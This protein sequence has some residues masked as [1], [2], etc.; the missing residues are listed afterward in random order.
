MKKNWKDRIAAVFVAVCFCLCLLA[1]VFSG[2]LPVAA[3]GVQ[4][5]YEEKLFSTDEPITVNFIIEEDDWNNMLQ[6][7]ISEEYV[8]C[9]VQVNGE[10]FYGVGVRPKGNTSLS[11]IANDPDTDRYSFKIE[12]DHYVDG[13]TCYGLDK[14]ILNNNYADATCMKEA[15]VY[16][17][18]Q[19][20]DADA[21][22]YNYAKI[23][24][25]GE[26]WGVY[27]A[28]EAVEDSFLLRNYGVSSGNLYKPEG[29]GIGGGGG[30]FGGSGGGANLNYTDDDPDSYETIWDGALQK[31]SDKDKQRVIEG[32]SHAA[33]GT[34][35]DEY[36]DIDNLLRYMAVHVFAA[37]EDSLS[38]TMAHNYY[39]YEQ[40][41][42]L[43]VLPWDY[44][45]AWGGMGAQN[46][47]RIINDDIY[48]PFDSTDFFD[49]LLQDENYLAQ[50]EAYLQELA[51]HYAESGG[52]EEFIAKNREK[53]DTLQENDPTAF[54][55]YEE[56]EAAVETL[57]ETITLR[58]KAIESQLAGSTEAID[59]G[60][61]DLSVMG[62]MNMGNGGG[63]GGEMPGRGGKER[64]GRAN[65]STET[66]LEQ[67]GTG[68]M[69]E[70]AT[71]EKSANEAP[72][73]QTP[74]GDQPGEPPT[75][76]GGEMP[77]GGFDDGQKPDGAPEKP[78]GEA[79][80]NAEM[81]EPP[82][83]PAEGDTNEKPSTLPD[84]DSD[85]A[86]QQEEAENSQPLDDSET[87]PDST[88]EVQNPFD[89]FDPS[90]FDGEMPDFEEM[91]EKMGEM[92]QNRPEMGGFDMGGQS[93]GNSLLSWAIYGGC[94]LLLLAGILFA[95]LYRRKSYPKPKCGK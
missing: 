7:A 3:Q 92:G 22:L 69:V 33:D 78:A 38:G 56:Y 62:T 40:D 73:G 72:G 11:S 29:M 95:T 49:A 84:E 89:G 57:Q 5:E 14:L 58:G 24:V 9:D 15:L 59:C 75:G 65:D 48:D 52:I 8:Q 31:V 26:Y 67:S 60:D 6:N 32:L 12:F 43:N 45:L 30:G 37:N 94:M 39:L 50:Y 21:S 93:N 86:S 13:Q 87:E 47:S 90:E 20:L 74:Q 36:L 27:L 23:S 54:Y 55:S 85:T 10:T 77:Q 17:M 16:Q 18:Y 1:V 80:D 28:L 81:Q 25:N 91:K 61:L 64:G 83:Q 44:N 53:I 82:A 46:A 70:A 63:M 66:E 4:V 71:E 19:D 51:E 41:G 79:G 34:D 88:E 42:K 2:S 35:L 76:M 68:E